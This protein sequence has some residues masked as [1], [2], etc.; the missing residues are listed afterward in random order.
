MAKS[1]AVTGAQIVVLKTDIMKTVE[2]RF[3]KVKAEKS[4][5][6]KE[7][8]DS[9][10]D[11]TNNAKEQKLQSTEKIMELQAEI[12]AGENVKEN[13]KKIKDLQKKIEKLEKNK[14]TDKDLKQAQLNIFQNIM[15]ELEGKICPF[16]GMNF[17]SEDGVK[18]H[19]SE[20]GDGLSD[21]D[22]KEMNTVSQRSTNYAQEYKKNM[23]KLSLK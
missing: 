10:A 16:C 23:M 3:E 20:K 8:K 2:Q 9:L 4:R 19:L 11:L 22:L 6:I 21:K 14:Y 13:R 5:R 17:G 1:K 7:W 12:D 15:T 18:S